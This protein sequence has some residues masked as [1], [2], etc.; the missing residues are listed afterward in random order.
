MN[1]TISVKPLRKKVRFKWAFEGLE[2][3]SD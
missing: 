3:L 2:D 1:E